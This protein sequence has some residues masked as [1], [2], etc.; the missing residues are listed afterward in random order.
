MVAKV[1]VMEDETKLASKVIDFP[2]SDEVK[3]LAKHIVTELKCQSND[4]KI[5]I[6]LE[7]KKSELNEENP[8]QLLLNFA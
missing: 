3:E 1:D 2:I 5:Q 8:D 7:M 6:V 4:A